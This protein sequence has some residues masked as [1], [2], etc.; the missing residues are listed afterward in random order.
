MRTMRIYKANHPRST[1]YSLDSCNLCSSHLRALLNIRVI[2][3]IR[4]R[5]KYYSCSSKIIRVRL[6]LFV[7]LV[8]FVFV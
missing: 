5:L 3:A 7:L 4:V 8:R 2:R 6:K 1:K